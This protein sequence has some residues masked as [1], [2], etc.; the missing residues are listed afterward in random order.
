MANTLSRKIEEACNLHALAD[1]TDP[2][3][4]QRMKLHLTKGLDD[5]DEVAKA[6]QQVLKARQMK[7]AG[8]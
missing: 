4:K 1:R 8:K 7:R 6:A 2:F 5:P 3:A